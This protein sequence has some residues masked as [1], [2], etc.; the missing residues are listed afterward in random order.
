MEAKLLL[1]RGNENEIL[2]FTDYQSK[3]SNGKEKKEE[4]NKSNTSSNAGQDEF[5]L[6]SL[7]LFLLG[8]SQLISPFLHI[9][10]GLVVRIC[11]PS[12]SLTLSL[13]QDRNVQ[14]HVMHLLDPFLEF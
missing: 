4:N 5:Q 11:D 13:H 8:L 6:P 14:E 1:L 7:F 10:S 3:I 12:N 9:V 2:R